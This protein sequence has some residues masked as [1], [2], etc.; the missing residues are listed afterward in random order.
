ME[1]INFFPSGVRSEGESEE[2]NR[3]TRA[4]YTRNVA[5]H[6]RLADTQLAIRLPYT[7]G[8]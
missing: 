6:H 2:A 8:V 4:H 1:K 5:R 3:T 7:E